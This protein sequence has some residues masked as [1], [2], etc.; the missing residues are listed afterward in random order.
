MVGSLE[1]ALL[2]WLVPSL[3]RVQ[4]DFNPTSHIL[5]LA[6]VALAAVLLAALLVPYQASTG[7]AVPAVCPPQRREIS[8]IVGTFPI[9]HTAPIGGNGPRAPSA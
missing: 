7:H 2:E 1:W 9:G 6:F 5:P 3:A 4:L 8:G